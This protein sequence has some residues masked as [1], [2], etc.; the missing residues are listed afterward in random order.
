[1]NDFTDTILGPPVRPVNPDGTLGWPKNKWGSLDW[2]EIRRGLKDEF[3]AF[4][5]A[6]AP[7]KAEALWNTQGPFTLQ[8]LARSIVTGGDMT[9]LAT[10]SAKVRS[11]LEPEGWHFRNYGANAAV[12]TKRTWEG[13]A[14]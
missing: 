13:V 11:V 7:E 9:P 10:F 1:M 6:E 3:W 8:E 12:F 14:P 4:V 2:D 5:M